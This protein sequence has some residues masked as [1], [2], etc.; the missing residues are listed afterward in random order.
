MNIKY[1]LGAFA[2]VVATPAFAAEPVAEPKKE[3]CCKKDDQGKMACCKEKAGQT[4]ED[5]SK[6]TDGPMKHR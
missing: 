2:L 1:L 5:H 6:H 3:C 4:G